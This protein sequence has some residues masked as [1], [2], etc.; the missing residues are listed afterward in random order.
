M[1]G[2]LESEP[3][4]PLCL[5]VNVPVARPEEIKGIRICRQTKGYWREEF[6]RREDPHHRAY[7]WLTGEFVNQEPTAEDTDEWALA[8]GY[9][10]VVPVQVDLTDY[11]RMQYLKRIIQ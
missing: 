9:V 8:N 4:L 1:R 7:F 10:A 5:N 6:Y 11:A 2:V 3:E